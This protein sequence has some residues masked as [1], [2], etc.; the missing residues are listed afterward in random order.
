[1][2]EQALARQ[3]ARAEADMSPVSSTSLPRR[4]EGMAAAVR[5][6]AGVVGAAARGGPQVRGGAQPSEA[7]HT[8]GMVE[9]ALAKGEFRCGEG[10]SCLLRVLV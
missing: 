2:R 8:S 5:A 1:V 6:R 3:V 4:L 9:Q 7:G 10:R